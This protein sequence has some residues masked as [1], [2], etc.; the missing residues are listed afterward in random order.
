MEKIFIKVSRTIV[1]DEKEGLEFIERFENQDED[2]A[3]EEINEMLRN[4]DVKPRISFADFDIDDFDQIYE[5]VKERKEKRQVF[6]DRLREDGR[7]EEEIEFALF[8]NEMLGWKPF[9]FFFTICNESAYIFVLE[10]FDV[11]A[12]IPFI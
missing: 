4:E 5:R 10:N 6:I 8:L 2:D 9:H 12:Y 1:L 11:S 3:F 7:S